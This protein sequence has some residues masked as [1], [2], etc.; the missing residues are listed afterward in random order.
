MVVKFP[1]P[2]CT[3]ALDPLVLSNMIMPV[4]DTVGDCV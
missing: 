1:A 2:V 4:R 3:T